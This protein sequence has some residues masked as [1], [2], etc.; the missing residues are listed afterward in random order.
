LADRQTGAAIAPRQRRFG[1]HD[2]WRAALW[3][4]AAAGA[5]LL[6]GYATTTELGRERI[7]LAFAQIHDNLRPVRS[8]PPQS[9]TAEESRRLAETVRMLVADR[10][11]LLAR[12]A[13][14]EHGVG[15]VAGTIGRMEK[16]ARAM[17]PAEPFKPPEA[18]AQP[19][20]PVAPAA[21]P[22]AT[23]A[24]AASGGEPAEDVTGS[25]PSPAAVPVPP[26]R[27]PAVQASKPERPHP[28]PRPQFGLDLGRAP[29]VE[30]LRAIW[31]T[32]RRRHP[33]QLAGLQPLVIERERTF[34]PEIELRLIVGPLPTAAAAA[35]LCATIVAAGGI[36]QPAMFEGQRLATR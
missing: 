35:R 16:A 15:D 2:L 23:P 18:D 12:I 30:V 36:C 7:K 25:I 5:L 22:T 3:G 11:R 20:K 32:A 6:A 31:L 9:L 33:A 10:E 17:P 13:A 28:A 24:A 27:A 29:S 19:D 1:L 4:V 8:K 21:L 26:P 14:L 34:P